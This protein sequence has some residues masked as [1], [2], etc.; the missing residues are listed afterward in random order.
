MGDAGV[1][2]RIWKGCTVVLLLDVNESGYSTVGAI[3]DA[4]NSGTAD[5]ELDPWANLIVDH[6]APH[7][8]PVSIRE[9]SE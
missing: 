4:A 9:E 7:P 5:I 1:K 2:I 6:R 8:S 3:G